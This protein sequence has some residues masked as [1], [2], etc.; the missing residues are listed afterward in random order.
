MKPKGMHDILTAQSLINRSMPA[1][2]AEM[3]AQLARMEHEKA[4]LERELN[5]WVGKQKETE[6]RLQQVRKHIELLK[7]ALDESPAEEERRDSGGQRAA[8]E[9]RKAK[10][11]QEIPLEY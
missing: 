4:R 8:G 3:V 7:R 6:G 5:V 9:E 2:R 11:W 1:T 10:G